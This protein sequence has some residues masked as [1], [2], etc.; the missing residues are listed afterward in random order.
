VP[1]AGLAAANDGPTP[2]GR[3]THL[4][5]TAAAGE[6][7][8]FTWALG[9]GAVGSGAAVAHTYPAVAV[10]TAV[11]TASNQLSLAT[12]TTTVTITPPVFRIYLPLILRSH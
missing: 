5:A 1:I 10:Y 6:P 4:A 3:P 2:L 12:A 9:D 11:V 8:T 7:I